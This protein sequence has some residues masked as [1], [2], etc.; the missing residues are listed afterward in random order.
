[1]AF[2]RKYVRGLG[3]E[4]LC[5][6]CDMGITPTSELERV[7]RSEVFP[8]K[9]LC[10]FC[11]KDIKGTDSQ[12]ADP[13]PMKAACVSPCPAFKSR[14]YWRKRSLIELRELDCE[15]L[16]VLCSELSYLIKE[17]SYN[18]GPLLEERHDLL[19]ELD[20]RN[21]V[22]QQLL[23]LTCQQTA[24]DHRPIQMSV[25][26]PEDDIEDLNETPEKE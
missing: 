20:A 1:M 13:V 2:D 22:I 26:F 24:L 23:K 19:E 21:I 5:D 12:C 17:I 15:Q 25:I 8:T 10:Q 11:A 18:L 14:Q 7:L 9:R 6:F 16:M 4:G 3:D